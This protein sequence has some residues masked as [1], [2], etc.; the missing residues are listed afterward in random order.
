MGTS[1]KFGVSHV[2]SLRTSIARS[3]PLTNDTDHMTHHSRRQFLGIVGASA[4]AGTGFAQSANAQE[5][6]IVEMGNNYFDPI[7][8]RVDPGTTVQCQQ[9]HPTSL[10]LTGSLVE[11]GA[12]P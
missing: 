10:T 3:Y 11:G 2:R 8:L 1:D 7:G 6:P 5:T 12:C 9:P 4:V